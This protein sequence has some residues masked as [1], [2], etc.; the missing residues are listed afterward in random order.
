MQESLRQS[1]LGGVKQS[2]FRIFLFVL[3]GL[4]ALFAAAAWL[5]PYDW[6]PDPAARYEIAATQVKRDRSY[7]WVTVHLKKSGEADHDLMK[8]VRLVTRPDRELEPADTTFVGGEGAGT[9]EIWVKFWVEESETFG[10]F[11]L[12]INDGALKVKTTEGM[13]SIADGMMRTFTNHRW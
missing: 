9:S 13:P 2:W 8:P 6:K 10:P 3:L 11:L 5:L 4:S 1:P 12:K 7:Y